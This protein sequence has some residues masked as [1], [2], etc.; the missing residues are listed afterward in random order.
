M[1]RASPARRTGPALPM[2]DSFRHDQDDDNYEEQAEA[3]AR[4]V[5]PGGAVRPSRQGTQK[6]QNQNDQKKRSNHCSPLTTPAY[7]SGLAAENVAAQTWIPADTP[8]VC[9]CSR[10][11]A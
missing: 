6:Q 7:F 10:L 8:V 2:L 3:A 9:R 11:G 1:Q 4:V 5:A